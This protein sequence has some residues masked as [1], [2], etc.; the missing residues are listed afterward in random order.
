[1]GGLLAKGEIE[2]GRGGLLAGERGRRG[3]GE[4]R[5][6]V[7][8]VQERRRA[9]PGGVGSGRQLG[10]GPKAHEP[11]PPPRIA[12]EQ[13]K[14]PIVRSQMR[15]QLTMPPAAAA[16]LAPLLEGELGATVEDSREEARRCGLELQ[17]GLGRV[18]GRKV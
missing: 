17:G 16:R 6:P 2:G 12:H 14:F 8:L 13:E 10:P 9:G 1:M 11:P 5:S 7:L 18:G 4:G 3:S 15:L